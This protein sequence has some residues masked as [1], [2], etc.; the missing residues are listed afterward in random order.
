MEN[1]LDF[2]VIG[3]QKC[4]TTWI[5]DILDQHSSIS[6]PKDK[7]EVEYLG[8][9]LWLEKGDE[10]Y[11]NLMKKDSQDKLSGDVSVEYIS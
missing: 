3:S 7:R 10:W 2:L 4:A 8:G 6:L 1:T 5:Y 11:F 9:K